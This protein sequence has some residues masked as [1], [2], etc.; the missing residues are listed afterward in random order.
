MDAAGGAKISVVVPVYKTEPYLRKCLDSIV[1]QTWQDLEII[2]VDDGSP[3]NCP[4][5]CEEY[6]RRDGRVRV[7]HQE[8]GG[9]SAARNTGLA[10][11]TGEWL[12]WVDSDDWIEPDMYQYLLENALKY[13]ADVAVCGRYGWVDGQRHTRSWSRERVLDRE[14]ALL[15]LVEAP[16]NVMW[17][18]C[19]DRL[20]RRGL[21]EGIRFPVGKYFEDEATMYR[22][23]M[24]AQ[25]V[26]CLPEAKY[27]YLFRG[28]S[29]SRTLTTFQSR[30]DIYL[31]E[32][33]RREALKGESSQLDEALDR[34][35][36]KA[37]VLCWFF[38]QDLTPAE[39][40]RQLP[41]MREIS[42]FCS[43]FAGRA[44]RGGS[45]GPLGKLGSFL[46]PY[47]AP[48]SFALGAVLGWLFRCKHR[49]DSG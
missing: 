25:R 18:S 23:F 24:R 17:G 30:Y 34:S 35:C 6:A 32:K 9:L 42:A 3:D 19:C 33:E 16:G 20:I 45:W 49:R 4:A 13:Q 1:N 39:R 10:A 40:E 46:L 21:W 11:A 44:R 22:V 15:E 27:N 12:G 14:Q 2:L 5:I 28:G 8:N 43:P 26:V 48:W 38:F 47:P 7:I 36:V 41:R 29:I 37:A 31:L